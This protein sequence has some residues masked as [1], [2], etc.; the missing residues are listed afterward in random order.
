MLNRKWLL[1]VPVGALLL[2]SL[3][4]A[5]DAGDAPEGADSGQRRARDRRDGATQRGGFDAARMRE[6]WTANIKEQLGVTDAEWQG[7][8]PKV[9]R[10]VTAQRESRGGFGGFAGMSGRPR[11]EEP[12]ARADNRRGPRGGEGE[13][14]VA[15]AQRE[16]RAAVTDKSTPDEEITRKL[17]ALREARAKARAALEEAQKELKSA[18]TPR[19]EA[20]LVMMNL[21]D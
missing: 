7:L 2:F 17:A 16:L 11:G 12:G 19:Q 8:Q 3:A 13:S 1:C 21:L 18:V 15:Q 4:Q 5:Q 20:T 9:E 14:K 10:V 6:R